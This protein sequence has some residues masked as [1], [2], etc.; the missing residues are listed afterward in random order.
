MPGVSAQVPVLS[1]RQHDEPGVRSPSNPEKSITVVAD[2]DGWLGC[3]I[4]GG[5]DYNMEVTVASVDP[6][7]PA[8][9]A[10]LKRGQ[11]ISKVNDVVVR[12]LTHLQIV[13]L[14]TASNVVRFVVRPPGKSKRS[15]SISS[16]RGQQTGNPNSGMPSNQGGNQHS[17]R[18]VTRRHSS[19][20]KSQPDRQLLSRP[21]T[22]LRAGQSH[23]ENLAALEQELQSTPPISSSTP[24]PPPDH[25]ALERNRQTSGNILTTVL[26]QTEREPRIDQTAEHHDRTSRENTSGSSVENDTPNSMEGMMTPERAMRLRDEKLR[27]LQQGT[28][29]RNLDSPSKEAVIP[30]KFHGDNVLMRRSSS[31]VHVK[32]LFNAHAAGHL[33][34]NSLDGINFGLFSPKEEGDKSLAVPIESKMNMLSTP[35]SR[36]RDVSPVIPLYDTSIDNYSSVDGKVLNL[37]ANDGQTRSLPKSHRETMQ[38]LQHLRDVDVDMKLGDSADRNALSNALSTAMKNKMSLDDSPVIRP[39]ITDEANSDWRLW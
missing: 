29:G 33:P 38:Q 6:L 39:N 19:P 21:T 24:L 20:P 27:R 2:E 26:T 1:P 13:N 7:S 17:P 31:K 8:L 10:G 4:R 5:S 22:P 28:V 15:T 3:S 9:R 36:R 30:S 11:R 34:D 18:R 16:P 35:H 14:V 23:Q 25:P 12:N 37:P 32:N